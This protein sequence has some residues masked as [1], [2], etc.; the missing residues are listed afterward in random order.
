MRDFFFFIIIAF[1]YGISICAQEVVA[2]F[3]WPDSILKRETVRMY[4][5]AKT[6]IFFLFF[7]SEKKKRRNDKIK[8]T[9]GVKL[10][11]LKYS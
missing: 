3:G 9:G 2:M 1:L 5:L 10:S 8:L 6:L 7:L 4:K 11:L